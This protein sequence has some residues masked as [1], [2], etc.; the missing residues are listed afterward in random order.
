MTVKE[1]RQLL[2][3]LAGDM[4]VV[5]PVDDDHLVSVCNQNSCVEEAE[6]D[7]EIEELLVLMPCSCASPDPSLN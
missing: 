5:I 4:N 6:I 1:L 3:G 2:K 7:G